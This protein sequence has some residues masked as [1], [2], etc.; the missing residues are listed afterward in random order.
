[1]SLHLYMPT[2]SPD[3]VD[4]SRW[5]KLFEIWQKQCQPKLEGGILLQFVD[6]LDM[7]QLSHTHRGIDSATDVLSFNYDPPMLDAA[8]EKLCGEIVICTE[9]AVQ[10]AQKLHTTID[11]EYATLFV[12]GLIHLAGLDHVSKHERQRFEDMTHG[13]MEAGGLASVSLWL[14]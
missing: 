11:I 13:I 1:M 6:L 3:E 7:R 10:N 9:V 4:E 8:G 14:D 2:G 5:Q 12:H